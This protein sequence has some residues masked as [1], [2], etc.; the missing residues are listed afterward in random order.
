MP[1]SGM[2]YPRPGPVVRLPG[3]L[4]SALAF[5]QASDP[6]DVAT[7]AAGFG[8]PAS[9]P[10]GPQRVGTDGMR[11]IDLVLA[12]MGTL[13]AIFLLGWLYVRWAEVSREYE[14]EAGWHRMW[15]ERIMDPDE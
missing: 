9:D 14:R 3:R 5:D 2:R 1:A 10:V 11:Y 15:T 4:A 6:L 7:V 8:A 12:V 13:L